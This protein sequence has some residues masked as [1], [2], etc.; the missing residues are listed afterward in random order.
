MKKNKNKSIYYFF[1]ILSVIIVLTIGSANTRLF[2]W[3]KIQPVARYFLHQ[4]QTIYTYW[5]S[6]KSINSISAQNN[7]LKAENMKLLAEKTTNNQL[8]YENKKLSELLKF[9]ELSKDFNLI[10]VKVIGRPSVGTPNKVIIDAGKN[11]GVRVGQGVV[12]NGFLVGIISAVGTKT[13]EV[14]LINGGSVK[15]NVNL[16]SSQGIGILQGGNRGIA[17]DNI[18]KNISIQIDEP[19]VTASL[20]EELKPG[21]PIGTVEK[22][23]S[24]QSDIYQSVIIK[25]PTDFNL[26][27]ILGVLI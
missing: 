3:E 20:S 19:V 18:A 15:V 27:D 8:E 5:L 2:L 13:S 9:Q 25:S 11:N 10:A 12:N 16:Q 7:Y 4:N 14:G 1:I 6:L 21:V 24:E 26:L 22:I 23:I 17:V